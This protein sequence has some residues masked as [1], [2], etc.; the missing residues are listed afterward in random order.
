MKKL[1]LLFVFLLF[2]CQTKF[3]VKNAITTKMEL[4]QL[5][6]KEETNT[7]SSGS[8]FFIIASYSSSETKQDIIKM[9][10]KID[11]AYYKM[12]KLNLEDI[13]I[14]IDNKISKPYLQIIN[15]RGSF[16]KLTDEE[17]IPSSSY[18]PH[19][20]KIY[21]YCP[22]KYLPEKLLEINLN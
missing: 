10:V 15:S 4:R 19:S 8:Y 1:L 13:N 11:N 12:L 21:L 2:S 17:I 3:E 18:V 16:E 20:Y 9:F 6:N 7:H 14:V 22:E 5:I